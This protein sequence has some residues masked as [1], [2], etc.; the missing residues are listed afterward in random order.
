MLFR[1]AASGN[2]RAFRDCIDLLR[3]AEASQNPP[4]TEHASMGDIDQ[5]VIHGILQRFQ[6][7]D[8]KIPSQESREEANHDD[9][10]S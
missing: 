5:E 10:P 9:D 1:S 7:Q 2:D 4:A 8:Q 3:H 6:G